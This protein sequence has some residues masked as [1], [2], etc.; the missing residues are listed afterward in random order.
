MKQHFSTVLMVSA[1][2]IA[3]GVIAVTPMIAQE[4][5]ATVWGG[6][7]VEITMNA[8]GAKIEFDCASGTIAAPLKVDAQ[9]KFQSD[10]TYTR[11]R[12]GPVM[13]D[14]NPAVPARY[15]GVIAGDTMHL[16]IVLSKSKESVGS[17]VLTRGQPGRVFKCR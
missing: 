7:H 8:T 13:K 2:G 10:G 17:Y 6:Q 16:E 1:L 15:S 4:T 9:G 5:N 11:E 12:P 14:G 3:L